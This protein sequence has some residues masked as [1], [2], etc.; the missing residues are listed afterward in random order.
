MDSVC[1]PDIEDAVVDGATYSTTKEVGERQ[2]EVDRG[3]QR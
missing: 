1:D 2:T 3:R